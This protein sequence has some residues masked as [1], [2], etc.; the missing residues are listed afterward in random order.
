MTE[1]RGRSNAPSGETHCC[2]LTEMCWAAASGLA[3]RRILVSPCCF[4]IPGAVSWSSGLVGLRLRSCRRQITVLTQI[5]EIKSDVHT[6]TRQNVSLV[7][8]RFTWTRC[9]QRIKCH[10]KPPLCC[11]CD[12][13]LLCPGWWSNRRLP[14]QISVGN[15]DCGLVG[16]E[17]V[18]HDG[19]GG[20]ETVHQLS[21]RRGKRQR[22][23][24]WE[25]LWTNMCFSHSFILRTEEVVIVWQF[26]DLSEVNNKLYKNL[27]QVS[28]DSWN[29][30][31]A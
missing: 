20:Q 16:E 1:A 27:K 7:L 26:P 31:S 12:H 25:S 29:L 11:C 19:Q 28:A 10:C 15:G 14:V 2:S 5:S 4:R 24:R 3:P 23:S 13:D 17:C 21:G 30:P 18:Q 6:Q 8:C 9:R 22:S